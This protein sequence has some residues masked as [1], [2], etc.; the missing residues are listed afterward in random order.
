LALIGAWADALHGPES[1]ELDDAVYAGRLLGLLVATTSCAA[2]LFF[3]G[4]GV[5]AET[6]IA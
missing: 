2:R 4:D 3:R 5:D 6:N 1:E